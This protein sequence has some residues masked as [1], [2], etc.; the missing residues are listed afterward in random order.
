VSGPAPVLEAAGLTKR[1]GTTLALDGV[2]FAVAPGEVFCLLGANG[3]GKTTVIHLFLGFTR[4]DAGTARVQ[5]ID[6]AAD[7]LTARR[8]VAF[9][10][11]QVAL[12]PTLSGLENLDYFAGL[13]VDSGAGARDLLRLLE[14]FGLPEPIARSPAATY[15]RGMRQRVGLAIAAARR[16]QALLLDEP[17]SGL[18]PRGAREFMALVRRRADAGAAVL[19]TTHDLFGARALG[20]RVGILTRGRLVAAL[21]ADELSHADLEAVYFQL[22]AD[23]PSVR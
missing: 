3:A 5:G 23:P 19:M 13:S 18:D 1:Y 12:Y 22:T 17:T 16:A 10:P 7:A 21:R 2:S 20:T 8:R 15:S 14:D 11:E 6:V 4:P 9:V